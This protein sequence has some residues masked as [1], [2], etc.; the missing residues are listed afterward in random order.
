MDQAERAV[1]EAARAGAEQY[2][3]D[4]YRAAVD[5]LARSRGAVTEGDYRLALN[6]ALDSRERAQAAQDQ[7]TQAAQQRRKEAEQDLNDVK[8]LVAQAQATLAQADRGR[9]ARKPLDEAREML[10]AADADLQNA[11]AQ[12]SAGDFT[13]A[14]RTLDGVRTR[15]STATSVLNSTSVPRTRGATKRSGSSR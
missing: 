11:G 12:V 15:V 4:E 9:G 3:P 7:A 14:K 6:H 10:H 1:A 13:G 2:A 5:A 8:T